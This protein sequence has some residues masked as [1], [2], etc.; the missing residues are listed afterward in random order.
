VDAQ[1]NFG[2]ATLQRGKREEVA[3]GFL[4]E[5]ERLGERLAEQLLDQGAGPLITAAREFSP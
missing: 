1:N 5:A 3:F 4:T 2:E